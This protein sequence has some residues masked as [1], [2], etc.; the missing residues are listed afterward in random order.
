[1]F[2]KVTAVK[3]DIEIDSCPKISM[4][5]S[6]VITYGRLFVFLI[7][8][9]FQTIKVTI[10]SNVEGR[11]SFSFTQHAPSIVTGCSFTVVCVIA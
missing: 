6:K 4:C 8:A 9:V 11:R 7:F 3:T 2:A 1:M 10:S 5:Q